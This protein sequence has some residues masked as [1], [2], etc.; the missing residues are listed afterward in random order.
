MRPPIVAF[1][2]AVASIAACDREPPPLPPVSVAA[3]A[4][5]IEAWHAFR[6]NAI[7]GPTG[8]RTLL[9]LWWL[10]PGETTIGSDSASTIILPRDRSPRQLGTLHVGNDSTWFVAARG[11][12]FTVDTSK[13]PVT[14]ARMNHDL[15]PGATVVRY[16]SLMM[17]YIAREDRGE[18]KHA[19]RIRDTLNPVRANPEP[20]RYFPTDIALRTQARFT[21]VSAPDSFNIVGVLG[22]D[23][24]MAHLGDLTFSLKGS[25]YTLAVIREPEDHGKNLFLMFTDSTNRKETYPATRYVWV[26]PPDSLGRT[27]VDFNKAFNP[28]CAFTKFSTCPF[29]PKGN[30]LPLRVEGGEWNPSYVEATA[31]KPER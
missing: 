30:H 18:I 20:I 7:Y 5:S 12:T 22:F 26:L 31:V 17:H 28:P 27:I 19:V 3:H 14:S 11:V 16:G 24:K 21:P 23:T 15:A 2:L 9:G 6:K 4:D 29:P 25:E 1:V 10:S 8:W 13:V